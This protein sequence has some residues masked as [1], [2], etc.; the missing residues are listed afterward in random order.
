[1]LVHLDDIKYTATLTLFRL[2]EWVVMPM[3]MRNSPATHQRWVTLA[4]KDLIGKICHVYLDN[5]II[6]SN[7]L[8]E[9]KANVSLV[10]EALC[11]A[12]LYCSLEKSMLFATEVDFLG[13]HI[14]ARGIEADQ[15]KVLRI[16]NWPAPKSAKH[17]Q[18]FL[19]LVRYITAFLPTLAEYTAVLTPL[20]QKECN[21]SFPAWMGN[22]QAAF[23]NIKRLVISRDC[24][25]TINH[26]NPGNNKIFVTCNASKRRTGAVLS[27]RK[28]WESAQP[29]AFES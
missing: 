26:E 21:S 5:V 13:H 27:F 28:T 25:T 11:K 24:L 7:T 2:W 1:M 9:H 17:V 3:G 19:G 18:Q 20:T 22:H 15:S 23:E 4:L 29:V 12:E 10:L 6:W 16:L 14:S 8:E